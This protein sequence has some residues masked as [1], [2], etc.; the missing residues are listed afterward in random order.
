MIN[1]DS[2]IPLY[3][4]L[5]ERLKE[6]IEETLNPGDMIPTEPEIEKMYQVSRVT[7]RKAI[8]E[9]VAVGLVKK[10]QG[11]GT[12]VQ[13]KII[14]E[15]GSITSW[16]EEMKQRGHKTET[17]GLEIAEIVPSK[18][19]IARLGLDKDE[20]LIC[21]KRIRC[22]DGEPIAL[23][24]NYL[25]AKFV[26]GFLERGLQSESLYAELE[27]TY[28]IMLERANELIGAREASELEALTLNIPPYS[29]VLHIAR[30]SYLAD[31]TPLEIVEMVAR[32]DRYQYRISLD[33]RAKTKVINFGD[34]GVF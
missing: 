6:Y 19:M 23:M 18:K 32:A 34:K 24:I 31:G 3:I 12:F 20:N 26:P 14:Q 15:M 16:T 33:G 10:Q 2:P 9:L 27:N 4:Q 30:N 8:D 22:T 1:K 17:K 13:E 7:V 28:G 5:K 25:R 11:R 29:P 21:I